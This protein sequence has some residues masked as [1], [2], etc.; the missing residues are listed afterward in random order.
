MQYYC[1]ALIAK[2]VSE[3]QFLYKIVLIVSAFNQFFI[4]V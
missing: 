3:V 4:I 2:S 1:D